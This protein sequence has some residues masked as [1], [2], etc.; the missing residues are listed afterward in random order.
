MRDGK[1]AAIGTNLAAPAGATVV[2]ATGQFVTPGIIDPHS[3]QMGDGGI[4]EGALSVTT[5]VR[6]ED[7]LNPTAGGV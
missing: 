7:I 6:S 1:I 5:L 4:N 2:D 3:H